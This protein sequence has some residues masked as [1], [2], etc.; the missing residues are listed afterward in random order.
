MSMLCNWTRYYRYWVPHGLFLFRKATSETATM[1]KHPWNSILVKSSSTQNSNLAISSSKRVVFSHFPLYFLLSNVGLLEQ[2]LSEC[3]ETSGPARH[4]FLL[5]LLFCR[6][7]FSIWFLSLNWVWSWPNLNSKTP[8]LISSPF[9]T[10]APPC[11]IH[12][13]IR[14]A[15]A[16]KICWSRRECGVA[17]SRNILLWFVFFPNFRFRNIDGF[18]LFFGYQ[19]LD[20]V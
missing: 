9:S 13:R 6:L 2:N 4:K 11:H 1:T 14:F 20:L 12:R 16:L 15:E 7:L 5:N 18:G 19:S 17:A 10:G 3:V 8:N